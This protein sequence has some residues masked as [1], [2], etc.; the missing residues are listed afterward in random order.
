[1]EIKKYKE[2]LLESLSQTLEEDATPSK[3]LSKRITF[4]S[5]MHS[6]AK[7]NIKQVLD[8]SLAEIKKFLVDNKGKVI[9][10]ELFASES[11][12]PNYDREVEPKV[13]LGVGELSKRR[14]ATIKNYMTTWLNGLKTAGTISQLPEFKE[15]TP[16]VSGPEWAPPA[17]STP[18]QIQTLASSK[19]YTDAQYMEVKL[20][21]VG[22]GADIQPGGEDKVKKFKEAAAATSRTKGSAFNQYNRSLFYNYSYAPAAVLGLS[23]EQ[24]E[25]L[26]GAL[27]TMNRGVDLRSGIPAL[28]IPKFTFGITPNGGQT[29]QVV[30]LNGR[31]SEDDAAELDDLT[32]SQ[33]HTAYVADSY[34]LAIPFKEGTPEWTAAWQFAQWYI[35]SSFPNDWNFIAN[36]PST[37]DWS[38]IDNTLNLQAG[39]TPK[40]SGDSATIQATKW[41]EF[42]MTW[43]ADK[44][45]SFYVNKKEAE[46]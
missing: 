40:L 31:S 20:S 3:S 9:Q 30:I 19:Q 7:S 43:Y 44:V 2:W 32:Y 28:G 10:V 22:G 15:T 23:K 13:K 35:K 8:P 37:I 6:A 18:E 16:I 14:Y 39:G 36:K 25:A 45:K 42:P 33:P 46:S 4:P 34:N 38:F 12:V 41:K 1:M 11:K 5:G 21:V 29:V 24:A 17:G 27:L 26:P